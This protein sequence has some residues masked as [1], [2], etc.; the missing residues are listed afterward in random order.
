MFKYVRSQLSLIEMKIMAIVATVISIFVTVL[1]LLLKI[2]DQTSVSISTG[3]DVL[4]RIYQ[5]FPS[6]ASANA[7][8]ALKV[9]GFIS[10]FIPIITIVS[11]FFLFFLWFFF[12]R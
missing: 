3:I 4:E 9:L 2:P 10:W 1:C 5:V 11:G 7:I 6:L 8:L 12:K